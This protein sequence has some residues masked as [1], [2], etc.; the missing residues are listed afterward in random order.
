VTSEERDGYQRELR[1]AAKRLGLPAQGNLETA[2][3]RYA[4]EVIAALLTKCTPGNLSELLQQPPRA[5]ALRSSRFTV[6][7][8]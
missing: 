5:W 7:T 6:I 3:L 2:L 1:A 4:T 8:I